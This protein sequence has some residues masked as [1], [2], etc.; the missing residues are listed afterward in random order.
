VCGIIART[1]AQTGVFKAPANAKVE[2]A[3]DLDAHLDGDAL[4]KLN[5]AGVNCI[6]AFR[7]RGIRIWGARTLSPDPQWRY[8]NVRRLIL[9]VQRWI[10]ANMAWAAF[11][12]NVPALWARIQ[13]ELETYLTGLWRAGALQGDTVSQAFFVRCDAELNSSSTREIG[14]VVTQLGLAAAAPAEFIIVSVQHRAG[15][16]ELT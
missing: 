11:E 10:D 3:T 8:L 1:D 6:R 7:S 9:T 16:T 4:V 15:T 13:R 12:P 14:Q 2:D 5:E